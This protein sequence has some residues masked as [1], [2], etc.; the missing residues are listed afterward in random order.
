MRTWHQVTAWVEPEFGDWS[1]WVERFA[2]LGVESTLIHENPSGLS[3]FVATEAEAAA[4]AEGLRQFGAPVEV[5]QTPD[6]NWAEAWKQFFKPVRVG[7]RLVVRPSWEAF[8]AQPEDLVITLDPGEAFGTGDH[9]TTRMCLELLEAED[10]S[11]KR[12][13]DIGCGTGILSIAA[14]LLGAE[15]AHC[16]D[17][18]P[19][20][21]EA[22][23][24]NAE[25]NGV[26]LT[27]WVGEGFQPLPEGA[28][29]LVSSNIISAAIIRLAPE[30]AQRVVPGG[31]WVI[32]GVVQDNWPDVEAAVRRAGFHVETKRMEGEWVAA[33]LRR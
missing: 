27:A 24:A 13:A 22:S 18:D 32:S 11:G 21:V 30:A 4:L 7:R 19:P 5:R 33:T 12:V 1:V 10:P 17:V 25:A 3:G 8:Q 16:V 2:D 29:P 14:L 9:P 26:R 31:A 15:S 20:A 23:L 28:Y 6:Q